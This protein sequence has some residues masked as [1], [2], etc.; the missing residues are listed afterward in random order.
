[1]KPKYVTLLMLAVIFGPGSS[2]E[3]FLQE[4]TEAATTQENTQD[5]TQPKIKFNLNA[6]SDQ[7]VLRAK[8]PKFDPAAADKIYFR[9]FFNE[10]LVGPRPNLSLFE[11]PAALTGNPPPG[12]SNGEG[13]SGEGDGTDAAKPFDP[14]I[15]GTVIEDEI[16]RATNLL[17]SQITTPGRFK[18]EYQSVHQSFSQLA[19][20]FAINEAYGKEVRW[21]DDAAA[22]RAS[23]GKTAAGTRVGTQQA[24]QIATRSKD[25][26]DQIVRGGRSGLTAPEEP[27]EDWSTVVDRTPMMI[28]LDQLYLQQLKPWSSDEAAVRQNKDAILQNAELVAALSQVILM[29]EMDDHADSDYAKH[30]ESMKAAAQELKAALAIENFAGAQTA[31]NGIGQSCS[32]CHEDFR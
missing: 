24:Y 4:K 32:N 20:L 6:K 3:A 17:P 27:F 15:S 13:G 1:M 22:F 10:A 8:R 16:K 28:W 23:L 7:P 21:H 12:S 26:L 18:T 29:P 31:I 30:A 9:D 2:A 5:K 19:T 14:L 11:N 25:D